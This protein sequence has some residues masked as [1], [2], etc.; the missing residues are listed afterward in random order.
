MSPRVHFGTEWV[1]ETVSEVFQE[2]IARFRVIMTSDYE[3]PFNALEKG[4]VPK[5]RAL[6]LHNGTV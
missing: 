3:D 6:Q 1:N 2:D 4:E 5:L